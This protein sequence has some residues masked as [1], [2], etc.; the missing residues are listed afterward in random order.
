[1][2]DLDKRQWEGCTGTKKDTY[3]ALFYFFAVLLSPVPAEKQ[4]CP[5]A[6]G[7]FLHCDNGK[8]KSKRAQRQK[9][10]N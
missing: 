5:K 4:E 7:C 1:M 10:R 6:P 8:K 3:G 9:V 2:L